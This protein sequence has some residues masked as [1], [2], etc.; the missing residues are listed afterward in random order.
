MIVDR[1]IFSILFTFKNTTLEGLNKPPLFKGRLTN[2]HIIHQH[3]GGNTMKLSTL[4]RSM[5][6]LGA[7]ALI[8]NGCKKENNPLIPPPADDHEAVPTTLV[9][10]LKEVGKTDSTKSL[11]RDTTVVKGKPRIEDTLRVVSGKTYS[12]YIIVR[13]ESKTTV[14]DA[15]P[16][17]VKEQDFHLFVFSALGG[18][19]GRL[20]VSNLSKDTKGVDLGLTFSVA[21]SGTGAANGSLQIKLRHYGTQPKTSLTY[22]TDLDVSL[23]V[24]IQ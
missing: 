19:N 9:V 18:A 24:K 10:V 2:I 15:T 7:F 14:V 17:I 5:F 12:G 11:V 21:V 23:P 8:I 3:I 4:I 16:E 1:S 13:D 20:T 6:V 22:D